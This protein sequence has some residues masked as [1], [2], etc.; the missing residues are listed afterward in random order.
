MYHLERLMHAWYIARWKQGRNLQFHLDLI[1]KNAN[2]SK[3]LAYSYDIND[4]KITKN[5]SFFIISNNKD[6]KLTGLLFICL[7]AM[8]PEYDPPQLI[9]FSISWFQNS[10]NALHVDQLPSTIFAVGDNANSVTMKFKFFIIVRLVIL[11]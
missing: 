8:L 2:H 6:D 7:K 4:L 11:R 10:L 1:F 3:Y 9:F 5:R